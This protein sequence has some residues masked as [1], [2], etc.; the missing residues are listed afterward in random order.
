MT[1]RDSTPVRRVILAS[2]M[3]LF[4]PAML[5]AQE[6]ALSGTVTDVTDAVLP[7]VTVT[8]L[9]TET[10]NTF[11]GVTD[12]KG[13]YLIN[14]LRTGAYTLKLELTGFSPLTRTNL[15]LQVGQHVVLN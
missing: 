14:A 8:A 12:S 13:N 5:L 11:V 15:E 7:G 6:S 4:C 9:H 3:L 2:A 10:G 1:R